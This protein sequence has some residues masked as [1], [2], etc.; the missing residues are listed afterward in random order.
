MVSPIR[1]GE[2]SFPIRPGEHKYSKPKEVKFS[3]PKLDTENECV[4]LPPI[5]KLPNLKDILKVE[6]CVKTIDINIETIKKILD[7]WGS[8]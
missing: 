5:K 6:N 1:K 2:A 3:L 7:K 8:S 4:K